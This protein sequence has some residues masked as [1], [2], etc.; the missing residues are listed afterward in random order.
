MLVQERT[1]GTAKG[2]RDIVTGDLWL[3]NLITGI[4]NQGESTLN[5]VESDA[6]NDFGN[7]VGSGKKEDPWIA[8]NTGDNL[9]FTVKKLHINDQ[10][11]RKPYL[12][13][14]K[15]SAVDAHYR[16]R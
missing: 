12:S 8:D 4:F 13:F 11:Q 14:E 10:I 9:G 3:V 5:I 7:T 2:R 6:L 15:V 1:W 16:Q